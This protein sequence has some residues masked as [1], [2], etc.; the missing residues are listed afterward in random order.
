MHGPA[1]GFPGL[2]SLHGRAPSQELAVQHPHAAEPERDGGKT[3]NQRAGEVGCLNPFHP[4]VAGVQS[5]RWCWRSPA[6]IR[7][8]GIQFRRSNMSQGGAREFRL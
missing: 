7:R 2:N 5:P 4:E 8:R 3:Q 1:D 6:T